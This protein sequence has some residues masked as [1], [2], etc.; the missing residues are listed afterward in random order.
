MNDL[1]G[2]SVIFLIAVVIL[3][4]NFA[5]RRHKQQKTQR[6]LEIIGD[7][8][9]AQVQTGTRSKRVGTGGN[10]R[11][12]SVAA[13]NLEIPWTDLYCVFG[14]RSLPDELTPQVYQSPREVE[15]LRYWVGD[16]RCMALLENPE[17]RDE[18]TVF[19][20]GDG[21]RSIKDGQ[22]RIEISEQGVDPLMVSAMQTEI[23]D[24][25]RLLQRK[26]G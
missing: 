24:L 17:L 12:Y 14:D 4:A 23:A 6:Y 3:G 19:L 16:A 18:I 25:V 13:Y 8:L 9:A 22:I 11:R 2:Y 1:I 20:K 5:W 26:A 15:P 10:T 7:D 21:S